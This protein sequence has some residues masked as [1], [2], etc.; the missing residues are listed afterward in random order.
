MRRLTGAGARPFAL[1]LAA[2]ILLALGGW[3]LSRPAGAGST[4][5]A[6][7][8]IAAE[9]LA[10]R[11]ARGEVVLVDVRTPAEFAEGH[12]AGALSLPLDS[13]DPAT[14]PRETGRET[15]LY[16]RS[17]RRSGLAAQAVVEALGGPV[18]HLDG[19]I[20]AWQA[21]GLPVTR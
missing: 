17:D 3:G 2:A 6:I 8:E 4:P 9:A 15:I 7:E 14:L 16:C 18:R 19:G 5:A 21:A 1:A 13:F 10:A 20:V 11:M 12:I